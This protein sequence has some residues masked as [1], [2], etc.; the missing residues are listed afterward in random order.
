MLLIAFGVGQAHGQEFVGF[1]YRDGKCVNDDGE[2]GRNPRYVGECGGL[3][4]R[5]LRDANLIEV[6][7]S[8]ADM[9]SVEAQGIKLQDAILVGA[10]MRNAT[11]ALPARTVARTRL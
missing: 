2:E 3:R 1:R 7:L 5:D 11:K 4:A 8:G 9:H 10:S 6:D